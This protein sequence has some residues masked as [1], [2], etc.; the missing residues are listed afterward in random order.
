MFKKKLELSEKFEHN[1]W[2][3]IKLFFVLS[4]IME[5]WLW[6]FKKISQCGPPHQHPK[7]RNDMIILIDLGKSIWQNPTSTHDEH[8]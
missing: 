6:F 7:E 2:N 3:H 5:W 8:F 4:M 1:I